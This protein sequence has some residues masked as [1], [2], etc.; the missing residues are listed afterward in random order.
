MNTPEYESLIR[1]FDIPRSYT[2]RK[3]VEHCAGAHIDLHSKFYAN[4]EWKKHFK[5][6]EYVEGIIKDAVSEPNPYK[7]LDHLASLKKLDTYFHD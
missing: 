7:V 5:V 4:D 6:R 2:R 3:Q 1:K